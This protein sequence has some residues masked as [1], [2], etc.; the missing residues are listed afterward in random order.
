M[1]NEDLFRAAAVLAAVVVFFSDQLVALGQ[2][3]LAR[4]EG[5]KPKPADPQPEA[6]EEDSSLADMRTI[7]ELAS[8]LKA[9]GCDAGVSLCQQLIDVML[10][11]SPTKAKK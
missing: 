5:K 6:P 2:G 4:P 8:R 10:G 11:S 1:T 3:F 9:R 7:L